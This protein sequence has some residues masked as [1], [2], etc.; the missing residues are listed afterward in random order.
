M[1]FGERSRPQRHRLTWEESEESQEFQSKSM[2]GPEKDGFEG[3]ICFLQW[4]E[5]KRKKRTGRSGQTW[6]K[7]TSDQQ[8]NINNHQINHGRKSSL[9]PSLEDEDRERPSRYFLKPKLRVQLAHSRDT[10]LAFQCFREMLF[11]CQGFQSP[12]LSTLNQKCVW[13]PVKVF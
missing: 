9:K 12:V 6:W 2:N 10:D 8:Q 4:K 5:K 3:Q 11:G 13:R 7:V 1:F